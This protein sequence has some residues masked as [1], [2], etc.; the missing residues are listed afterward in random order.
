MAKGQLTDDEILARVLSKSQ[1]AVG[2]AQEKLSIERER[3]AKY[4]NGEWPRR[5]SEGSSSFVSQDVYDSVKMQQAQLLEVFATGDHIAK[6]DPDSQ[7]SVQDC[8]VATEY[9]SYCIFRKNDGYQIF[10]DA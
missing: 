7:M 5:N 1:D 6:F 2:W 3:V 8:L 10:S 9:A 4:L